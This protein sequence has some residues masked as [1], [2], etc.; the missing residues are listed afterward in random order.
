MATT[1]TKRIGSTPSGT[2]TKRVGAAASGTPTKRFVYQDGVA[3]VQR[4]S[5]GNTWLNS[6][7]N[8][9]QFIANSVDQTPSGTQ[10]KRIPTYP[11]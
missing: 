7:G 8:T 4:Y 5:W 3:G 1:T 2:T 9:W 11:T 6:W 10:T